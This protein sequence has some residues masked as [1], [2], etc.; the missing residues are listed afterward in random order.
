MQ[1]QKQCFSI[2]KA[3]LCVVL[4]YVLVFAV[5]IP[6]GASGATCTVNANTTYQEIQG[7]GASNAW[8]DCAS[9]NGSAVS[10]WLVTHADELFTNT[11]TN[12]GLTIL[13]ARIAPDQGSWGS[14]TVNVIKAARDRG[15]LIMSTAWTP[16]LMSN[17]VYGTKQRIL[18]TGEP[19][20]FSD[21]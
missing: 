21:F 6:A 11:G 15:A 10:S 8:S 9:C 16:E 3:P 4:F 13:R 1:K 5:C 17:V 14:D 20:L 18:L 2:C 12:I 7:F 19:P